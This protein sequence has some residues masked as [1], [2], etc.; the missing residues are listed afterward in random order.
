MQDDI[1]VLNEE[2]IS[3]SVDLMTTLVHEIGHVID[4]KKLSDKEKTY[5]NAKS[6]LIETLS[7]LYEKQ[8]LDYLIDNSIYKRKATSTLTNFYL[9]MYEDI[10]TVILACNIPDNL[11]IREKYKNISISELYEAI[12]STADVL[13]PID[14]I[15]E[16][17]TIDLMEGLEYGYGKSLATYFSRLKKIDKKRYQ[18][19]Y[20]KFMG[21]R[22]DYFPND[23]LDSLGTTSEFLGKTIDDDIIKSPCKIMIKK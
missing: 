7:S 18:D 9:D 11:V 3:N 19:E 12:S 20:S 15:P 4:Y 13:V 1:I 14:E 16:P 8:F 10:N 21:L 6:I 22:T 23:F 2:N 5:Y 17:C